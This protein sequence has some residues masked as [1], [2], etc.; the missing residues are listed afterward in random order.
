MAHWASSS[1]SSSKFNRESSR[2]KGEAYAI[3]K[4]SPAPVFAIWMWN[5]KFL[6]FLAVV[7]MIP[8]GI[9]ATGI[10]TTI[11]HSPGSYREGRVSVMRE[12]TSDE[13]LRILHCGR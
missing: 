10:V 4:H 6:F 9:P 3:C 2:S 7:A 11:A 12:G 8:W 5:A 1:M 13:G